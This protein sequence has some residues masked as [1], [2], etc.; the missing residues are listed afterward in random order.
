[1]ISGVSDSSTWAVIALFVAIM[2][3]A[4]GFVVWPVWRAPDAR[5]LPRVLLAGAFATLV[6]GIGGGLYL[7]LGS[8]GLAVRAVAPPDRKDVPGLIA[9]LSQ[10]LRERP[11]DL[12]GWTLLGRGYLSLNDPEQAAVAFR[13]ASE[14]AI[15]VGL[16]R[17]VDAR[18]RHGHAGSGSGLP[19]RA[20]R[21]AEGFR[22]PLL[23]GRSL[24]R[25]ARCHPC[26]GTVARPARGFPRE[27]TLA[28]RAHRPH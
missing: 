9:A 2:L 15:A 21:T 12:T 23:S 7:Y 10:R 18:R 6:I 8:P 3:A 13:T 4:V 20:R 24:C 19:C 22:R 1:M 5:T 17:S 28:G 25:P 27:R 11:R 26:A 16:W 14:T